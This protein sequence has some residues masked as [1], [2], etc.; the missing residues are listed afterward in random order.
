MLKALD[1]KFDIVFNFELYL[2]FWP[3]VC[4]FLRI[5]DKRMIDV[6]EDSNIISKSR[7]QNPKFST[8]CFAVSASLQAVLYISI[9]CLSSCLSLLISASTSSYQFHVWEPDENP[10]AKFRSGDLDAENADPKLLL[11]SVSEPY[12]SRGGTPPDSWLSKL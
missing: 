6:M 3:I 7:L 10:C 8:F 5:Y 12:E 9:V 2:N 1:L 4:S 11:L